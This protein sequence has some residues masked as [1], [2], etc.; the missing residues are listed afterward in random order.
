MNTLRSKAGYAVAL[1]GA[2]V[3]AL[4]GV[5]HASVV[6][7][8]TGIASS[9]GGDLKDT[10]LALITVLIPLAIA[11]FLAKKAFH[12]ARGWVG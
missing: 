7:G 12:M 8:V 1:V 2:L 5:A 3:M 10:V 9:A 6:T 4:T 11:V